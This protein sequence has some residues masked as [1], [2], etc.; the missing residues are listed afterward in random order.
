MTIGYSI[1]ASDNDSYMC[2]S[3]DKV[4]ANMKGL[5]ICAKCGYR[6]DFEYINKDFKVK[7]RIYDISYTYDGYCIVSIKFKEACLRAEFSGID[8]IDLPNDKEFFYLKSNNVVKFDIEKRETRF[9]N[10]CHA[11]GNYGA[12]AGANPAFIKGKLSSDICRTDIMF[13]SGNEKHHLLLISSKAK[14]IVTREKIRG[15]YF[16]EIRT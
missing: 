1:T 8:F 13:G 3:C 15:I 2:S 16:E 12:I 10:Y 4:H 7:K 6:T 14:D 5:S 9:E 11:C